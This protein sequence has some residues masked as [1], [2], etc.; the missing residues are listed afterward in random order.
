M[1]ILASL[2]EPWLNRRTLRQTGCLR[3]HDEQVLD[4]DHQPAPF[5][6]RQSVPRIRIYTTSREFALIVE[7]N[8]WATWAGSSTSWRADNHPT[9]LWERGPNHL[10]VS[11]PA[12]TVVALAPG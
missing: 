4:E 9:E 8:G 1:G 5:C 12:F 11:P 2:I 6:T 7:P 3:P 10:L